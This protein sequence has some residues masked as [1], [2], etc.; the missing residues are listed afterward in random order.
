MVAMA[1]VVIMPVMA[2]FAGRRTAH[3]D[4][5]RFAELPVLRFH[6][7]RDPGHVGDDVGTKPHRIGRARLTGRIAA[8]GRCAIETT[9]QQGEQG[10][11]A[12][13]VNDPHVYPLGLATFCPGK[14]ADEMGRRLA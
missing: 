8:L 14:F 1:I 4:T 5:A 7:R 9:K 10:N 11:G 6:A 3:G 12:S 13:Q 2:T